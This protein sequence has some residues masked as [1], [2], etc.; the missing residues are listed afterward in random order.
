VSNETRFKLN[1][2]GLLMVVLVW[3]GSVVGC[4]VYAMQPGNGG[5]VVL[6]GFFALAGY[7]M[8]REGVE[9]V[10]RSLDRY[11]VRDY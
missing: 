5:A 6:A 9:Q 4:T 3:L 11:P 8:F 10:G 7:G 1:L 2:L